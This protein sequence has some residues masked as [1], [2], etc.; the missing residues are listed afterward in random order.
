[1]KRVLLVGW[2]GADWKVINPLLD[3]GKMPNLSRLVENG[4]I[5]NLATLYP[6]L[7]PM[8]WTTI[9]TGKRPFKHGILGFS[10]PAPGGGVRP[11][12]NLSRTTR[13]I[14]NIT[15]LLNLRSNVVGWWPSHPAEPILGCMV[16]DH[17][18]KAVDQKEKPWPMVPGAVHPER[19]VENLAAARCHPEDLDAGLIQLFVPRLGEVDQEKDH[20]VSQIART[21]GECTSI[22]NAAAALMHFEPWV[23]TCVY[24]DSIDHFCH[25]F[26]NY[27]PPRP[28]WVDEKDFDLYK[29][30][31]ESGYRYHDI[32][33][34]QLLSQCDEETTV[35]LV[36]DHGFHSDHLRPRRIPLEPA[37]PAEQHRPYGIF[38]ASGPGIRKDERIYGA[39]VLDVV[40]TILVC[41]GLPVGEDMDGKV[42]AGIFEKPPSAASLPSWDAVPGKD[43]SHPEG[44]TVDPLHAEQAMRQLVEL[45]YVEAPPAD[46][47]EAVDQCLRELDYNK[48]RC[49]MDADLHAEAIPLL[50][51]LTARWPGEHRFGVLL[52]NCLVAVGRAEEAEPMLEALVERKQA[53]VVKAREEL[54]EYLEKHREALE[55]LEKGEGEELPEEE[56]LRQELRTL[57]FRA[58]FSPVAVS[59]L[60]GV[61]AMAR[62]DFRKA[63]LHFSQAEQGQPDDLRTLLKLG[64]AARSL[65]R[66][67]EAEKRFLKVVEIDPENA[68][69]W[70]GLG[71]TY[72]ARRRQGDDARTVE[73]CTRSIGL[74]Y[75]SPVAHYVLGSVLL[76]SGDAAGAGKALR[77]AVEQNPNF[78]E[79]YRQLAIVHER[80][81]GDKEEAEKC[82]AAAQQARESIRRLRVE[83]GRQ[84]SEPGEIAN[85]PI[86][87]NLPP[88]H[89]FDRAESVVVVSGLPR[90]GTSMLMQMLAAGGLEPFVDGVRAADEDNPKGYFEHEAVKGLRRDSG[91]VAGA[92]GKV[93]K[94][95]AHI[96][97]AL[98]RDQRYRVVFVW[99]DMREILRS[100]K[101]MLERL[102]QG[103]DREMKNLARTYATQLK[104]V[105]SWL[106]AAPNADVLF[107]AFDDV[108]KQPEVAV[109]QLDGFLPGALDVAAG[110]AMVRAVEPALRR[111]QADP[112]DSANSVR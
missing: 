100:Q 37:G 77:R 85:P 57:R 45:G 1:M 7:S 84:A 9:A 8:L 49:Y 29:D 13:A 21:I 75:F 81:L 91:W 22:A 95:V 102:G 60:R 47:R 94:V 36:S 52:V 101:A 58:A 112:V 93:V 31:V 61:V 5:G 14:W 82:R 99:R 27:H 12:T 110:A 19:I 83:R 48:A 18:H 51:G 90:S 65:G 34:G 76:R 59:Y 78:P 109:R 88:R 28:E 72:A 87:P 39:T 86:P 103:A 50:E 70:L 10:E 41:L 67:G 89:P 111:Q 97:P 35:V 40:P 96:L 26:M 56:K 38:A 63:A 30:V 11:I 107:L 92:R 43:G 106:A 2:D 64:D 108:V 69:A 25:G 24:F 66:F 33:L 53:D 55:K 105:T 20:R 104:H 71:R 79:A 98:P 74:T 17:Y 15:T 4:V 16:S 44:Q 62:R 46:R 68:A 6:A 32:L 3:A 54:R 23:L 80:F 42:L 73:A